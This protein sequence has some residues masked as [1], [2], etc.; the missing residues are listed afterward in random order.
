MSKD[1]LELE[2][3]FN[4][5]KEENSTLIRKI[6][7][8]ENL[9]RENGIPFDSQLEPKVKRVSIFDSSDSFQSQSE[10]KIVKRVSIADSSSSDPPQP[11][12]TPEQRRDK[13]NLRKVSGFFSKIPQI[14]TISLATPYEAREKDKEK[15]INVNS[16]KEFLT[17]PL[18]TQTKE[19]LQQDYEILVKL[20]ILGE[21]EL[22]KDILHSMSGQA[23]EG[24]I[25]RI[26]S[27]KIPNSQI[28]L[29]V[30]S[31]ELG[32]QNTHSHKLFLSGTG[33]QIIVCNLACRTDTWREEVKKWLMLSKFHSRYFLPTLIVGYSDGKKKKKWSEKF[34]ADQFK[35]CKVVEFVVIE[36]P[37]LFEK[38]SKL[39]N[40]AVHSLVT[41]SSSAKKKG[42]PFY[43]EL[44]SS[45][46]SIRYH[47]PL[48]SIIILYQV[49]SPSSIIILYLL[50]QVLLSSISY[51]PLSGIISIRYYL[52][53][54]LFLYYLF[55]HLTRDNR[56]VQFAE[57]VTLIKMCARNLH[58]EAIQ[59]NV[60][61]I[62][63]VTDETAHEVNNNFY[64]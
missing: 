25:E 48:S 59:E 29:N 45:L 52:Y 1:Y 3:K 4:G 9:L 56:L 51:Y 46:S 17:E 28:L 54:F 31:F 43:K 57:L 26:V 49:L 14:N 60:D 42:P 18:I 55:F 10:Q 36:N 53:S 63:T 47:Y 41:K 40:D 16:T 50:Y 7:F 37:K 30:W 8:Y 11:H 32:L 64:L 23:I 58:R 15:L 6:E 24:N 34:L 22:R 21:K 38:N 44:V 27:V 19:N 62:F 39:I 61:S 13:T 12:L 33:V 35:K 20:T 2:V 5:L